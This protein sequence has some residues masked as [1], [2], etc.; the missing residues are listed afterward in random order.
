MD[1]DEA[2]VVL[3]SNKLDGLMLS[4]LMTLI[5]SFTYMMIS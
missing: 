5:V 1:G 3:G 2:V 4:I